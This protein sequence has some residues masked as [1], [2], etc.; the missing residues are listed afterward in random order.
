MLEVKRNK[1]KGVSR[2]D[3]ILPRRLVTEIIP[4]GPAKGRVVSPEIFNTM[5]DE[6]YQVRGGTPTDMQ[7]KILKRGLTYPNKGATSWPQLLNRNQ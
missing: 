5:L 3:D 2:S 6:Y 7:P 4:D 1:I